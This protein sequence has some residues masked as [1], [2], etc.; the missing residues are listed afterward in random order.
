ML[1]A[2]G[3]LALTLI[4]LVVVAAKANLVLAIAGVK[5]LL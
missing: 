5:V 1:V 3:A 4:D 2:V